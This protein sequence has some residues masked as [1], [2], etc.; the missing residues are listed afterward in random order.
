VS[1]DLK[2]KNNSFA[3]SDIE[4]KIKEFLS[5]LSITYELANKDQPHWNVYY[6]F[7]GKNELGKF[8]IDLYPG[9]KRDTLMMTFSLLNFG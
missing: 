9:D 6:M 3:E 4:D 5:T 2:I 1:Y 8:N 7:K